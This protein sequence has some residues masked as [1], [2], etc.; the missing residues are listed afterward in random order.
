MVLRSIIQCY[1][2]N[3]LSVIFIKTYNT[4]YEEGI[5]GIIFY[6]CKNKVYPWG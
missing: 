1:H 3:D 2:D 6:N 5:P 4:L